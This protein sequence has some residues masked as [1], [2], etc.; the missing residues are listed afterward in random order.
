MKLSPSFGGGGGEC[1]VL[2]VIR[3][4]WRVTLYTEK[5]TSNIYAEALFL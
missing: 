5:V 1:K 4:S 2:T 3:E